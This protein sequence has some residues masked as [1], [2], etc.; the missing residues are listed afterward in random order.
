MQLLGSG[1]EA[2]VVTVPAVAADPASPRSSTSSIRRNSSRF[3]I[4]WWRRSTDDE[5]E[6]KE[7]A[8]IHLGMA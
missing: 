4:Q 7:M 8:E 5:A 2:N 1:S 3:P 6:E